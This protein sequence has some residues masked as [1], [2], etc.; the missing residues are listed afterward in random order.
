MNPPTN[1]PP[2][3]D[4]P[5]APINHDLPQESTTDAQ[6]EGQKGGKDTP[7]V[8]FE[9]DL[10]PRKQAFLLALVETG[11]NIAR[12]CK[13]AGVSPVTPYTKQW[14]EDA[15]YMEAFRRAKRLGAD[16]L[17]AEAVRRAHDGV[18]EPAGW[19]KGIPGGVVTKYSDVLLIFLLKGA[20][21][22]KYRERV[23]VRGTLAGF[24]LTRCSD[25][26]L[27]RIVAGEHPFSVLGAT[28]K[29]LPAPAEPAGM[30]ESPNNPPDSEPTSE[31]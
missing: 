27:A 14:Q 30:P 26:Q 10:S 21:P 15:V 23:E 11:G 16:M 6:S 24:D 22:E 13:V 18:A 3:N 31:A 7:A 20:F 9:G 29:M 1:P 8:L 2:E 25:D 12:A 4:A 17:E 5:S 19:Y 28:A